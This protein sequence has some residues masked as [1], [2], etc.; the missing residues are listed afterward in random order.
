MRVGQSQKQ[1][2]KPLFDL[3][4]VWVFGT[5][6]LGGLGDCVLI[7]KLSASVVACLLQQASQRAGRN[8]RARGIVVRGLIVNGDGPTVQS[9]GFRKLT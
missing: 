8:R 5:Q 9:F 2:V 4:R 6:R 7:K 3:Q 1:D